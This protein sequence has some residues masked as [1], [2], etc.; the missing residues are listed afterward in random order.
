MFI[1]HYSKKIYLLRKCTKIK[2]INITVYTY[3]RKNILYNT[4]FFVFILSTCGNNFT[5]KY[6]HNLPIWATHIMYR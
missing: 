4:E 3:N 6:L 2:Y 1:S 5:E